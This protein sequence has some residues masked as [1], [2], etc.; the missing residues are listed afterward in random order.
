MLM[1]DVKA[2]VPPAQRQGWDGELEKD[3]DRI[4]G[5]IKFIWTMRK[6]CRLC[7]R[8]RGHVERMQNRFL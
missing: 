3:P 8:P 7:L 4:L 6:E 2:Q 1:S 5:R